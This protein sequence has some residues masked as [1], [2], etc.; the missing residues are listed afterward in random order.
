M[1]RKMK[2]RKGDTVQ[3]LTGRRVDKG[4]QGEVIKVIPKTNRIVVQGINM[5]KKHQRQQ[6][7][8]GSNAG[9]GIIEFEAQFDL[10][11]VMLVCP[12]CKKPARVGYQRD[13]EKSRRVCKSC[14]EMLD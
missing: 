4:R 7:A 10:S 8:Q 3:V 11:N 6:Q 5:S 9:S 12:K 13:D 2:I 14:N 1:K